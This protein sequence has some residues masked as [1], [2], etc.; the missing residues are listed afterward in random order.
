M[1]LFFDT[2]YFT[3]SRLKYLYDDSPLTKT[4]FR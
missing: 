2:V 3:V 4:L 1:I